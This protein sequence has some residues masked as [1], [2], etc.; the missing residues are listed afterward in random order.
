MLVSRI[1]VAVMAGFPRSRA[2][3]MI[4]FC[5]SGTSAA[6]ISTPRSPRR[7]ITPAVAARIAPGCA[8]RDHH[9]VRRVEDRLE[10]V[11]RLLELDLRDH[12]RLRPGLLDLLL[13]CGDV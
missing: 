3:R 2:P 1:W 4:R 5:S 10:L 13:Q 6:P 11:D 8:A 12:P 9:R 7:I